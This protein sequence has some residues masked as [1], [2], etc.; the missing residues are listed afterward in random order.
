MGL[1]GFMHV[2][3]WAIYPWMNLRYPG[4]FEKFQTG[5]SEKSQNIPWFKHV[6]KFMFIIFQWLFEAVYF[7]LWTPHGV[8]T[9]QFKTIDKT[10]KP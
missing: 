8:E 2:F 3:A 4:D 10:T 1:P 7:H 5:L 9:L 6:L